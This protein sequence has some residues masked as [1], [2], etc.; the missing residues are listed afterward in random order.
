MHEC[1]DYIRDVDKAAFGATHTHTHA[2]AV[3]RVDREFTWTPRHDTQAYRQ[4]QLLSLSVH[5]F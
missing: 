5:L 3:V 2:A 1:V 4:Q